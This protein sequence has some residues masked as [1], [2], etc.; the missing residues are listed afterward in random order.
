MIQIR[1]RSLEPQT[2]CR[3]SR[4]AQVMEEGRFCPRQ[5]SPAGMPWRV[6]VMGIG[7][8]C[9]R[10][11][12]PTGIPWRVR[13]LVSSRLAQPEGRTDQDV[14]HSR[15]PLQYAAEAGKRDSLDA[16]RRHCRRYGRCTSSR[17]QNGQLAQHPHAQH[18]HRQ[19]PQRHPADFILGVKEPVQT[20][21]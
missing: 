21:R 16:A 17:K 2:E 7:R 6:Q 15:L 5:R 12:S 3:G 11:R 8:F 19:I 10:Q 14:E 1:K 20:Q 18:A 4:E 13:L 9:R